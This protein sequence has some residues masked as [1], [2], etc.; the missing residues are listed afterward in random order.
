M[1]LLILAVVVLQSEKLNPPL[2]R[3]PG[4]AGGDVRSAVLSPDATWVVYTADQDA[5]EVLELYSVPS[6]ASASSRKLST[7]TSATFFLP[8]VTS[9]GTRVVYRS[10][11]AVAGVERLY[12]VPVDGSAAP[13]ELNGSLPSGR[14]VSD[15]ELSPD[16]TRALYL[17]SELS[18]SA[19]IHFLFSVP[20][21]GSSARVRLDTGTSSVVEARFTNDGSRIV[22]RQ[23]NASRTELYSVPSD[24]S[25][26]P[27]RLDSTT[28]LGG[29]VVDFELSSDGSAVVYRADQTV[30]DRWELFSVPTSG[31]SAQAL[32]PGF[33]LGFFGLPRPF[34]LSPSGVTVVFS[35]NQGT[36][37]LRETFTVPR[38]ASQAPV[39]VHAAGASSSLARFSSDGARILF[40]WSVDGAAEL[41]SVP[42]DLTASPVKL[43]DLPD[44]RSARVRDVVGSRV[45]FVANV[46]EVNTFDLYSVPIDGSL[47][48]ALLALEPAG[49]GAILSLSATASG[50]RYLYLEFPE[51]SNAPVELWSTPLDGSAP[52][53]R[54]N[55][56][57]APHGAVQDLVGTSADGLS[58]IYLAEEAFDEVV[59]LWN[60][61]IL[62]GSSALRLNATLPVP[63]IVGDVEAF[64]WS[65]EGHDVAYLADQDFDS[66]PEL[67]AV[68][69]DPTR[70]LRKWNAP[71][72]PVEPPASIGISPL[73]GRPCLF[74]PGGRVFYGESS[75]DGVFSASFLVYGALRTGAA[76]PALFAQGTPQFLG[77]R[78][79]Y[80]HVLSSGVTEVWSRAVEG[81]DTPIRLSPGTN[82]GRYGLAL[83]KDTGKAAFLHD[84]NVWSAPV[85]GHLP[86]LQL[87]THSGA[88]P[89]DLRFTHAGT[90]VVF[91]MRTFP[92]GYELW[93]VPVDGSAAA[94]RLSPPMPSGRDVVGYVLSPDGSRAAY[95]ADADTDQVFELYSVNTLG[96]PLVKLNGPLVSGGDVGDTSH[97]PQAALAFSPDGSRVVYRADQDQDEVFELYSVPALGGQAPVKLN[98]P[99]S[100]ARDVPLYGFRITSD[101]TRV[102]FAADQDVAGQIELWVV[103]IDGSLAPQ[104]LNPPMVSGG[105][106]LTGVPFFARDTF[107]LSPADRHV[108]YLADQ[109][110]DGVVELFRVPTDGSGV[111][112]VCNGPLVTGGDVTAFALDNSAQRVL[113]RADEETDEVYELFLTEFPAPPPPPARSAPAPGRTVS[114]SVP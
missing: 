105:S 92:G 114:R 12:T 23:L 75:S 11:E 7:G 73:S 113:Y 48:P 102:V 101:S 110:S 39:R 109:A 69:M 43:V 38:D 51:D 103:P 18:P 85:D 37:P 57:L 15:F 14:E 108:F 33:S 54:A 59:E 80:A 63:P 1:V 112:E 44:A 26:A 27:V 83:S 5:N 3:D 28:V 99:L 55:G 93:S 111:A 40:D 64:G 97:E 34:A 47:Q 49:S 89:K 42:T 17:S 65:P 13:V 9:T 71:L 88:D 87:T 79:I 77:S 32:T 98:S 36:N 95:L 31:G 68:R 46:R 82:T 107:A 35:A 81:L 96:G 67:Y 21:D 8:R 60:A 84:G 66:V 24:G 106:L 53:V 2:P 20:S 72:S 30:N 76:T 74:A 45:V 25:G 56:P 19:F 10:D 16:G 29:N 104:Q 62:G 86:A 78:A 4:T 41:Y 22:Y 6:D 58:A 91:A 100:G 94:L 90:R 61:P 50:E 52:P 70:Y